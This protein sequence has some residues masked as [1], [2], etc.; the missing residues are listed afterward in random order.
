MQDK[1]YDLRRCCMCESIVP[2]SNRRGRIGAQLRF[3]A[4]RLG[5]ALVFIESH[6]RQRP[7][8]M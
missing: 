2:E 7:Q 8:Q 5:H 3:T 4:L 1:P 6:G